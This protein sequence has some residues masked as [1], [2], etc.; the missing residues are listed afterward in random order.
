MTRPIQLADVGVP[1]LDVPETLP[2]IAAA[3]FE[4]ADRRPARGG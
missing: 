3:E 4:A 2:V 1:P